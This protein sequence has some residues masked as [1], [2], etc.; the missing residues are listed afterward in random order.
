MRAQADSSSESSS[1]SDY[2]TSSGTDSGSDSDSD[3]K[4]AAPAAALRER[5]DRSAKTAIMMKTPHN[6]PARSQRCAFPRKTTPASAACA[7]AAAPA[8]VPC[9]GAKP[10]AAAVC[11]Y[12][13]VTMTPTHSFVAK[14]T[15]SNKRTYLGTFAT[16]EEA[17]H[18]YDAKARASGRPE[19]QLNF[20]S[21]G[22]AGAKRRVKRQRP[23]QEEGPSAA[24][25]TPP[26]VGGAVMEGWEAV[27]DW[28]GLLSS[29]DVPR[30]RRLAAEA[31]TR[32]ARRA[33]ALSASR[34]SIAAIESAIGRL[35][36]AAAADL[37]MASR[38]AAA[39]QRAEHEATMRRLRAAT[40]DA[41]ERNRAAE[42]KK[43]ALL[44]GLAELDEE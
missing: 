19:A 26:V 18:A 24:G 17:A 2:S 43:A 28:D 12:R 40:E 42:E 4:E 37:A 36:A 38:L 5:R 8:A 9:R 35:E 25:K 33:A 11:H 13:G 41:E 39:M 23:I 34:Q 1:Y 3:L 32:G 44:A 14:I 10:P 22:G 16:A 29:G 30:M 7:A 20:P 27:Q 31:Q 15:V 21:G 6:A